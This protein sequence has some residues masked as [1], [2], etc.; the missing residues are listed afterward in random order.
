M[1]KIYSPTRPYS[2]LLDFISEVS[3]ELWDTREIIVQ[4]FL[5]DFKAQFRQSYL[6]Y[7]WAF[8]PALTTTGIWLFLN[9][10]EIIAVGETPIPYVAHVLIGVT[11]WSVF[12]AGFKTPQNAFNSGKAVF[13]KLNV[14]PEVF[15]FAGLGNA[16]FDILLKLLLFIPLF[17]FLKIMPPATACLFPLG[18]AGILIL[19]MSLGLVLIPIGGLYNDVARGVTFLV[20]FLMY[21]TPV[22]YPVPK[23]GIAAKLVLFNPVA[24]GIGASR[25]W[26]TL[27]ASEHSLPFLCI[28]LISMA[29]FVLGM[30]LVRLTM[31]HLIARMGM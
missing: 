20:S 25:D 3:R 4:L 2:N 9:A 12:E 23:D 31:P 16:L 7:I 11:L 8:V 29:I 5:R 19:G 21:L 24:H 14:P 1:Q 22:V 28:T 26:L 15:I 6:G 30:F 17:I 13:T 27:G 10:Q 18:L